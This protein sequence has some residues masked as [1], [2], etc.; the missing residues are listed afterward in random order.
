MFSVGHCFVCESS[1]NVSGGMLDIPFSTIARRCVIYLYI[2]VIRALCRARYIFLFR[3]VLNNKS[4][5]EGKSRQVVR[6]WVGCFSS[7]KHRFPFKFPSWEL[8][9]FVYWFESK[10]HFGTL[11][12]GI[13]QPMFETFFPSCQMD[14]SGILFLPLN[15]RC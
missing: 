7:I 9:S 14:T 13:H 5:S 15:Y 8:A 11:I 10:A 12:F 3:L 4:A 1:V 2:N 6:E